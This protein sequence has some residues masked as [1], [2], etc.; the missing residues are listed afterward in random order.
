MTP[1]GKN[2]VEDDLFDPFIK[3]TRPALES[4]L[5]DTEQ[6]IAR[7]LQSPISS[8]PPETLSEIF[9]L[10]CQPKYNAIGGVDSQGI[11]PLRLSAVCKAWRDLAWTTRRLWSVIILTKSNPYAS[12]LGRI[13]ASWIERAGNQPLSIR[14]EVQ[15]DRLLARLIQETSKW[16]NVSIFLPSES[17]SVVKKYK[18]FPLLEH[19]SIRVRAGPG[20]DPGDLG[21][22]DIFN[23][24]SL[25]NII[26]LHV[27]KYLRCFKSN[28]MWSQ[29]RTFSA[30]TMGH[31]QL[32]DILR[33]ARF[34][35]VF[36]VNS[37][38]LHTRGNI[39]QTV[40][41]SYLRC[42]V[43]KEVDSGVLDRLLSRPGISTPNLEDLTIEIDESGWHTYRPQS[44]FLSNFTTSLHQLRRF[45]V[46][47]DGDYE[48]EWVFHWLLNIS[49]LIELDVQT[50]T[51]AIKNVVS[52]LGNSAS[53]EIK[54]EYLPLL[55][56]I[57]ITLEHDYEDDLLMKDIPE[58]LAYR[59]SG[60]SPSIS[61][62]ESA[63]IYRTSVSF[64][65]E[66]FEAF[67]TASLGDLAFTM[68]DRKGLSQSHLIL[69]TNLI[70][71][72]SPDLSKTRWICQLSCQKI[73]IAWVSEVE[74]EYQ[75]RTALTFLLTY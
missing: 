37:L 65:K 45:K 52:A 5:V 55:V 27:P 74:K 8:L 23:C 30:S 48:P 29:L 17:L 10:C 60:L 4:L 58:M 49:S 3:E 73:K 21:D 56:D 66:D 18:Y 1:L 59:S 19:F 7:L 42:L 28:L 24:F 16:M 26:R 11:C 62:L 70:C 40:D 68:V 35:E 69:L 63:S 31:E 39:L 75:I 25:P 34:L 47:Y 9:M 50:S 57:R 51:A 2:L 12:H 43:M 13:L 36:N 44:T 53:T 38:E 33:L 32:C 22:L 15:S 46:K 61:R 20:S 6:E 14:Y 72:S 71:R 54:T 67:Q 64:S 41:H